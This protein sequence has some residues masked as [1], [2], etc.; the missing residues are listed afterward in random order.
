[1]QEIVDTVKRSARGTA[2]SASVRAVLDTNIAVAGLLW[3]GKPRNSSDLRSGPADARVR[4]FDEL[5]K[6]VSSLKPH[7]VHLS[8]HGVMQ[9]GVGHFAFEDERGREDA[10]DGR[11]VAER[12]GRGMRLV[13]E[14]CQS[15]IALL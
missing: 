4:T 7:V 10:H 11:E 6:L 8:A 5:G 12:A 2:P 1:M 13:F 15:L 14:R 9:D 3:R